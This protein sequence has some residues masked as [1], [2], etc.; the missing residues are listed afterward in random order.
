[1]PKVG[2]TVDETVHVTVILKVHMP[3]D[4]ENFQHYK[5]NCHFTREDL[6]TLFSQVSPPIFM[7]S[8]FGTGTIIPMQTDRRKSPCVQ[9]VH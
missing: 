9:K 6:S 2:S 4:V 8:F 1:M 7:H 5:D 3:P